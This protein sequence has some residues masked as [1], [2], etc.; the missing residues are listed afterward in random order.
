MKLRYSK[1]PCN[2]DTLSLRY[3]IFILLPHIKV[4]TSRVIGILKV[5]AVKASK[6]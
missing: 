1:V 3:I 5:R 2:I 4:L 6:Y